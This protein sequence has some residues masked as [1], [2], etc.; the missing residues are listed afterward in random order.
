VDEIHTVSAS[1]AAHVPATGPGHP[2]EPANDSA[3]LTVETRRGIQGTLHAS[4]VA[5]VREARRHLTVHGTEGVLELTDTQSGAQIVLM[6]PGEFPHVM[7]L[8]DDLA[9]DFDAD[10]PYIPQLLHMFA[11]QPVGDR[12]FI[13]A[14]LGNA[15][16]WP[17]FCDGYKA[18]QVIDAAFESHEAGR[19]VTIPDD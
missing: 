2:A 5:G 15:S 13:D 19:R 12:L 18:Q 4:R 16:E 7:P 17:T 3:L 11:E 1:L 9:G 8:P 14:I 10:K 6:R